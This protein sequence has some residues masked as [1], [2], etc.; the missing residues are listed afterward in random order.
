MYDTNKP[1]TKEI[2]CFSVSLVTKRGM[3]LS[4]ILV[5]SARDTDPNRWQS[6]E[7]CQQL[8]LFK[9]KN[10]DPN[11]CSINHAQK[12]SYRNQKGP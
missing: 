4:V 8:Q 11:S 3:G 2:S 1:V 5:S 9:S 6:F 12:A 10:Q 7:K